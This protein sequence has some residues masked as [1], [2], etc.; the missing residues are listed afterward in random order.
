[1]QS[2]SDKK[3]FHAQREKERL[4]ALSDAVA[5]KVESNRVTAP[6]SQ[7]RPFEV[8][9]SAMRLKEVN[10]FLF[11]LDEATINPNL[12]DPLL[13]VCQKLLD[14]KMEV[15]STRL[16]HE[17]FNRYDNGTLFVIKKAWEQVNKEHAIIE[18]ARLEHKKYLD[19]VVSADPKM[20]SNDPVKWCALC[21]SF[22][23]FDALQQFGY[24]LPFDTIFGEYKIPMFSYGTPEPKDKYFK[25]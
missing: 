11:S 7:Y 16:S 24:P 17:F 4:K 12:K 22:R 9:F 6:D 2:Y 19:S 3:A 20:P 18:A 23:E 14:W 25:A 21:D 10:D 8:S 13:K 15:G 1:M 5:K